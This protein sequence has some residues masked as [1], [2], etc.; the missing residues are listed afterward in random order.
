[1]SDVVAFDLRAAGGSPTGVGRYML[2]VVQALAEKRPDLELRAYVRADVAGL[3]A[4]VTVVRVRSRGPLWHLRV[5]RHL[6]QNPVRAYCSTSLIIPALSGVRALPVVLD[7]ISF[8]FPQY[9]TWRTRLAERLFMGRAVRRHPVV[10][11]SETTRR[12]LVARFG[13]RPAAVVPPWVV[14]GHSAA[15]D[16]EA[17]RRLGATRPYALYVGTIEPRK[18]VVTAIEAAARLR[19]AGRD[20]RLVAVG[21][22]G[23]VDEGV[24]ARLDAAEK[25]GTLVRTGYVSDADRDALFAGA[26]CLV[27]PSEYEGF[28]LPLLEA[29]TRGLPSVCSTAPVFDEVSAGAALLVDPFDVDGWADAIWRLMSEPEL[30]SRLAAAGRRRAADFGVGKTAARFGDALALLDGGPVPAREDA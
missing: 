3:P 13:E 15:A 21:G 27:Q 24:M 10:V 12:D 26:A 1:V 17:L 30:A 8:L 29:L 7:L 5:W 18:N 20:V 25:E 14:A 9:H 16:P 23:W 2:L 6:R 11:E 22:R 19:A 4:R 28:G